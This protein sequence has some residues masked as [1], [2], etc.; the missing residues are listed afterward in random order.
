MSIY[1][2][3]KAF[4]CSIPSQQHK[5]SCTDTVEPTCR[6][7]T[8]REMMPAVLS[9]RASLP[10][11]RLL[12]ATQSSVLRSDGAEWAAL[13]DARVPSHVCWHAQAM[14]QWL[15]NRDPQPQVRTSGHGGASCWRHHLLYSWVSESRKRHACS[16]LLSMCGDKGSTAQE[17]LRSK[18]AAAAAAADSCGG[19]LMHICRIWSTT[20]FG[21][22]KLSSSYQLGGDGLKAVF[23]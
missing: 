4:L 17:E 13:S 11:R 5:E 18:T 8:L 20:E 3:D 19:N 2:A 16:L 12:P 1:L 21:D 10:V 7:Q 14:L 6:R 15:W 9:M 23:Q 22:W